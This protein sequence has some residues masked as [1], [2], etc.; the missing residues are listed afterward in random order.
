[1]PKTN[2]A[3]WKKKIERNKKRDKEVNKEL[4]KKGWKVIRIW[5][6]DIKNNFELCINEILKAYN[7][8]RRKI[9]NKK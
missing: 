4:K 9:F 6:Y 7:S 3:Y 5:E 1:M 2:I 8:K